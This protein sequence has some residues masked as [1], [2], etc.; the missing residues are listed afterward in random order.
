MTSMTSVSMEEKR[1]KQLKQQLFGKE[2]SILSQVPK[3]ESSSLP[4]QKGEQYTSKLQ[5]TKEV[6]K[7]KQTYQTAI[8]DPISLKN[9]LIKILTFSLAALTI[10]LSLFFAARQGLI[11]LFR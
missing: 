10:Q 1:L 7:S 6:Q 9:D 3:T 8:I 4:A 2:Q 11:N 5:I